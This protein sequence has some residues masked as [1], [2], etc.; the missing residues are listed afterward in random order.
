MKKLFLLLTLFVA[1]VTSCTDDEYKVESTRQLRL[2]FPDKSLAVKE[3]TRAKY[4]ANVQEKTLN[5]VKVYIFTD[6][7]NTPETLVGELTVT[8]DP[9]SAAT[10]TV[11]GISDLTSVA[12]GT[13]HLVTIANMSP[14]V[15]TGMTF[16]DFC[17]LVITDFPSSSA[18]FGMSGAP[19]K[20][21]Y[22]AGVVPSVDP[23]YLTRLAARIDI[24]NEAGNDFLLSHAKIANSVDRSYLVKRG[25]SQKIGVGSAVDKALA[26]VENGQTSGVYNKEMFA[27][28][29]TFENDEKDGAAN[30]TYVKIRGQYKGGLVEF[31]VPFGSIAITRNNRYLVRIQDATPDQYKFEIEVIDWNK[32][33]TIPFEPTLPLPPSLGKIEPIGWDN[34][35]QTARI[36]GDYE[37]I[38]LQYAAGAPE[39]K[40]DYLEKM[41][42]PFWRHR[43]DFTIVSDYETKLAVKDVTDLDQTWLSFRDN[44][45]DNLDM[46][47]LTSSTT[48]A[49][50]KYVEKYRIVLKPNDLPNEQAR[51]ITLVF[52]SKTHPD[53]KKE[54]TIRQMG[55]PDLMGRIS[56]YLND[57]NSFEPTPLTEDNMATLIPKYF[58]WGR[59][60]ALNVS[61]PVD[62]LGAKIPITS[63]QNYSNSFLNLPGN[64]TFWTSNV[65]TSKDWKKIVGE[66]VN[67]QTTPEW[68]SYKGVNDGDP[69]P[70]GWHV[71]SNTEWWGI[72]LGHKSRSKTGANSSALFGTYD[73]IHFEEDAPRHY[74][75]QSAFEKPKIDEWNHQGASFY[76]TQGG[77]F[78]ANTPEAN[79]IYALKHVQTGITSTTFA[80]G[81]ALKTAFK[82]EWLDKNGFNYIRITSRFIGEDLDNEYSDAVDLENKIAKDPSFWSGDPSLYK[83][84]ILP[85]YGIWSGGASYASFGREGYIYTAGVLKTSSAR[86]VRFGNIGT[87]AD[88]YPRAHRTFSTE[89]SFG[90]M[91]AMPVR[92]IADA[93]ASTEVEKTYSFPTE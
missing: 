13:Y 25:S 36:V 69:C 71:P 68:T 14:V 73:C 82:Y 90:V 2:Q 20:F 54:I 51:E 84:H 29:Y 80:Y 52:R 45:L 33:E 74:K 41:T 26:F 17:D 10:G 58:Q 62:V 31:D 35:V 9:S 83:T 19:V 42:I 64:T 30:Q 57:L 37:G 46:T 89:W 21:E 28:L 70:P 67:N 93:I 81:G 8:F 61:S 23:I 72:A 79:T 85:C 32:G 7:S 6:N 66:S 16:N 38:R 27:T 22:A 39:N 50:G 75:A 55:M 11:N 40:F 65:T 53:F 44:G 48:D 77:G 34:N 91:H 59:N 12:Y 43:F 49:Q 18:Y 24:K 92:C 63:D 5:N 47:G 1:V 87:K 86:V 60:V 4:P 78:G 56:P 15:T 76:Y 88:Q 3:N